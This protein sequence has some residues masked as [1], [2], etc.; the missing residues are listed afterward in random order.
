MTDVEFVNG[1]IKVRAENT[2]IETER[3][4]GLTPRLHNELER[5]RSLSPNDLN[6]SVFGVRSIKNSFKTACRNANIVGFRFRDCRHTATTRMVNSG[7]PQAEA[8]KVTGH[9]QLK[10]FLRY[11]NLTSESVRKAPRISVTL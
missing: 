2:K 11:V 8:M 7:M 3:I 6:D 5:L 9:T 4:V 1:I 10:T